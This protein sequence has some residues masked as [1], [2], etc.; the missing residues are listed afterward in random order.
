MTLDLGNC[1]PAGGIWE[2]LTYF[3]PSAKATIDMMDFLLLTACVET[4][5]DLGSAAG[6]SPKG[7][8]SQQIS[9]IKQRA[10]ADVR[11]PCVDLHFCFLV[12]TSGDSGSLKE[13]SQRTSIALRPGSDVLPT[14]APR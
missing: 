11:S 3:C 9:K 2:K 13:R 12:P 8:T 7:E 14:K 6:D 4:L 10:A 5:T 1:Q